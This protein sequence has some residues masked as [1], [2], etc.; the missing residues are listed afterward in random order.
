LTQLKAPRGKP[1]YVVGAMNT[2]STSPVFTVETTVGA[3]VAA[4]P[5]LSRLF[6]KLGIDFCCGGKKPLAQLAAAR[7]LDPATVLAMI[8]AALAVTPG[9]DDVNP[10]TMSLAELAD[11]IERTHHEYVKAE[12]PR[13]LEMA[14]RVAR[15][16]AWRD[17]RLV[18]VAE[19]VTLLTHEMFSHMEKEERI[20]FPLVRQIEAG[21]ADNFHCG[22]IANPIRQMEDEHESAGNAV[23]RLR[24]LTDGFR[25]DAEACN[26]HRAL[27]GGL[28]EFEGD[29]HRHVHK[30]NNVL[31]PRALERAAGRN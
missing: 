11:H 17:H 29:L 7:G 21:A 10:L 6:E 12:L 24:E 26:T 28:E 2:D 30:E 1:R 31:F 3:M 13:L 5:A 18:A 9:N 23:A 8:E 14:E 19:T 4:R 25:P 27:L 20:L 15:K 22:S 16:H